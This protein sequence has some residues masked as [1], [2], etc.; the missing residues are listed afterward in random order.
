MLLQVRS[1]HSLAHAQKRTHSSAA[2]RALERALQRRP[3]VLPRARRSRD[4]AALRTDRGS[5]HSGSLARATGQHRGSNS[6]FRLV[7]RHGAPAAA[8][9]TGN[10]SLQVR[11]ISCPTTLQAHALLAKE[12][13]CRLL[14]TFIS[15]CRRD[16]QPERGQRATPP[17]SA[18]VSSSDLV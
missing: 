12:D 14:D 11:N 5:S 8:H 6:V 18:G 13:S 10:Q 16:Q 1:R 15:F 17:A 2:A 4:A 9:S 7:V 3:R